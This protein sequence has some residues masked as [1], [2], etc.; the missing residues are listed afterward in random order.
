MNTHNLLPR[1]QIYRLL[2]EIMREVLGR[3][4]P[5]WNNGTRLDLRA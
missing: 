4:E 2:S 1:D 3:P 5:A